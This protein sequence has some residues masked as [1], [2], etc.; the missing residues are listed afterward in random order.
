[1]RH[2]ESCYFTLADRGIRD[3]DSNCLVHS[4]MF[5]EHLRHRRKLK[6]RSA[7]EDVETK[8]EFEARQI[9]RTLA[10]HKK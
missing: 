4:Q 8:T 3:G 7:I 6:K 1:M 2:D 5:L 10:A 9:E